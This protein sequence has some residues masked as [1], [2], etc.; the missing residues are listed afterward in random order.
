MRSKRLIK[1]KKI[2]QARDFLFAFS[3]FFAIIHAFR[4][5]DGCRED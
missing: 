5:G 3:I 2:P 1:A 4:N